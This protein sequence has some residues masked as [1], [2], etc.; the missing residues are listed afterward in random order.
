MAYSDFGSNG[1]SRAEKFLRPKFWGVSPACNNRSGT[2]EV[3]TAF[4]RKK[5][6][7]FISALIV[8]HAGAQI[9]NIDSR[10]S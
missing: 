4:V 3:F 1:K 6:D 5:D 8:E 7:D 2:S 10:D 9:Q